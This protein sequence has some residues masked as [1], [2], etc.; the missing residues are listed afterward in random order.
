MHRCSMRHLLGALAILS[1]LTTTE[2]EAQALDLG[3]NRNSQP[4]LVRKVFVN[5]TGDPK[6]AHRFLTFIDL[7]L[8]DASFEAVTTEAYADAEID[9]EVD[10]AVENNNLSLGLI[11]LSTVADNKTNASTSCESLSTSGE[12]E[13]FSGSAEKLATQ[14]R[15]TYPA[16]KKLKV[17]PAS[18]LSAS[19]VFRYN[20]P[21]FLKSS[22]FEVVDSGNADVS[23]RVDLI[24]V[25]VPI[26]ERVV[27]YKW[28]ILLKDS[29]RP[30]SFSEGT[31]I[32]SAEA[33]NPPESCP[34][35]AQN[36][37]WLA[38]TDPL[39]R[40]SQSIARQL[41]MTRKMAASKVVQK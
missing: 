15:R 5:V 18:N 24:R 40:E 21:T 3:I 25:K 30:S 38:N 37:D 6:L 28:R 12:D 33:P 35:R 26:E 9:A 20:L 36:L 22:T 2:V 32:L 14:L 19:K 29:S 10:A 39:F 4:I 7:E 1:G 27:K 41:R 13:L 11:R 34:D 23:L 16:A 8:E 31:G 17:D